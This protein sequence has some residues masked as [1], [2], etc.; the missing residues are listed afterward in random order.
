M[1]IP[2]L[3]LSVSAPPPTHP[4]IHS[5]R[6]SP[7]ASRRLALLQLLAER[8]PAALAHPTADTLAFVN[9][10]C[11]AVDG[12]A[13]CACCCEPGEDVDEGVQGQG[14]DS[15]RS[16]GWGNDDGGA[17]PSTALPVPIPAPAASDEGCECS[18][19]GT[20]GRTSPSCHIENVKQPR[21]AALPP[22]PRFG[23]C[24]S[25]PPQGSQLPCSKALAAAAAEEPGVLEMGSLTLRFRS[26]LAEQEFG[27]WR[28]PY[29]VAASAQAG[30][31]SMCRPAAWL[32]AV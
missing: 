18:G 28:T 23:G 10:A 3:P 1:L 16:G 9:F 12:G 27:S 7:S 8:L 13:A 32:R 29:Y 21:A 30:R 22:S 11:G 15:C 26:Q 5:T 24:S 2:S 6:A 4:P 19:C 31:R 17:G 14:G 20:G 25:A